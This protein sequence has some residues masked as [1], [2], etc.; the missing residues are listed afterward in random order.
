MMD[1]LTERMLLYLVNCPGTTKKPL[2]R[3]PQGRASG[4]AV[5][6][7]CFTAPSRRRP[8]RVPSHS[9]AVTGAPVAACA[10]DRQSAARLRG[11]VQ[12]T[13]PRL[14]S[15]SRGSLCRL[16]PPTLP[17]IV[18]GR[19]KFGYLNSSLH[20]ITFT[21]NWQNL[22]RSARRTAFCCIKRTTGLG[23]EG[24]GARTLW[25]KVK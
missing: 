2:K 5:V 19:M 17:F 18:F 23:S 16:C 8:L 24:D 14:F 22:Q 20:V 21:V 12:R 1:S 25:K 6:P 9:C 7:P 11:H 13:S 10:G 4:D 3:K 15:P